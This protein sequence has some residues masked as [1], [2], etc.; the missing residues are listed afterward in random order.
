M[1]IKAAGRTV[2]PSVSSLG[3]GVVLMYITYGDLFTFVIMLVAI[4]TLV[5]ENK[6]KK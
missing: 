2:M 4:I 1:L 3:K 6:H 5:R